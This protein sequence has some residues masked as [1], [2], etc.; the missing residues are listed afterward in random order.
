MVGSS[1]HPWVESVRDRVQFALQATAARSKGEQGQAL[2]KAGQLAER[3]GYDAFFLGDHPA[4]APECW[5]HLAVVASH[6]RRIRLGQMVAAAPYRTPLMTARLQ[7]DLDRLS[8]GRSV[9]G[10]GIGWN[11]AEHGLGTNEFDR[12][13]LP[14][15][16]AASRQAALDEAITIIR[17]VWGQS[18]FSYQGSHY[19]VVDARVDPPVQEGGVPFV[20]A[21]G[22]TR[23]LAQLAR[24]GDI[25]NFGPGPAG[26]VN[27][28]DDAR[29]RLEVLARQCEIAGREYSDILRTHFTHWLVLAP[30]QAGVAAKLARYFP[31]GLDDFW[32][33]YLVAGTPESIAPHYQAFIDAGIQYFVVQT[34][35][36]DDEESIALATSALEPATPTSRCRRDRVRTRRAFTS[37]VL[38]RDRLKRSAR[39]SCCL[40][41]NLGT[42][43]LV[44]TPEEREP[45]RGHLNGNPFAVRSGVAPPDGGRGMTSTNR[46]RR[47]PMR[48]PN[49][50][51]WISSQSVRVLSTLGLG[52]IATTVAAA[53]RDKKARD[54][55]RNS[56]QDNQRNDQ[57][58]RGNRSEG[59]KNR[60]GSNRDDGKQSTHRAD[61]NDGSQDDGKQNRHS[62]RQ[63]SDKGDSKRHDTTDDGG[64][65]N[66]HAARH[67]VAYADSYDNSS[68][69]GNG[70]DR[71]ELP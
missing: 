69:D 70:G 8:G 1:R 23:T 71:I 39:G 30:D 35:D 36:P 40:S 20:I 7:S 59:G 54:D 66:H 43:P 22:G 37:S 56:D 33:K 25:C 44:F 28:P 14:Y 19:R 11:A 15:P 16:P 2:L 27:S 38:A 18:P 6:T 5:L 34:L 48:W 62:D 29:N 10:L 31:Q 47:M 4:W 53:A 65:N 42:P 61:K 63:D 46:G 17:G 57:S 55:Q 58:D 12:M 24:L 50:Q 21:G 41:G 52:A 32:G 13:G 45:S 51:T 49:A 26:N 3:Y 67:Q 60:D 68:H 9:L 64:A